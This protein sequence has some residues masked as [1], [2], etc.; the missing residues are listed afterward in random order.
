MLAPQR[1]RKT[2]TQC[3]VRIHLYALRKIP[4]QNTFLA[5]RDKIRQEH[6]LGPRADAIWK[7]HGNAT[8]SIKWVGR[9]K[10]VKYGV[11]IPVFAS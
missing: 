9:I 10:G 1:L 4:Y 3:H 11:Q 7:G 5:W 8:V 6:K 2:V